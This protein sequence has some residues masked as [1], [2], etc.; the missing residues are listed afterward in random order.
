MDITPSRTAVL[1]A[2]DAVVDPKSGQGLALAG[3]V[4]G[5]SIRE[6]RIGFMLE[7]KL[8]DAELYAPVRARAEAALRALP[9]VAQAQV[10]LTTETAAPPPAPRSG[11]ATVAEDPRAALR[12]LSAARR[13]D[14]VRRVI[15]VASA[16]GGVGK[17]TV[18]ANLA[19]AFAVLGLRT[20]LA[21]TDVYGPS[22]PQMMGVSGQ[23]R[24]TAD[25]RMIPAE[26][27]GVKVTSIGLIVEESS[28]MI[29]RGPMASSAVN[30]LIHEA[31]WGSPAE[32]LDILVLDLPPGTGD[33]QLTIAQKVTL[34]GAV[35]V[36][37]PQAVAL[38][39]VRRGAAMFGKLEVPMLGVIEN[40][41]FFSDPTTGQPI[42]IFGRGGA[43]SLAET[44][45]A[46]F[47]G[48]LPIDIALRQGGDAGTPLVV[49]APESQTVAVFMNMARTLTD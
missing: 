41:A 33:I 14:H 40:M 47:L 21:D 18:A 19:C 30:Q 42:E 16:K 17:S 11:R 20:G 2:L 44:L 9:G 23:P 3:L 39:D 4:R 25:K 22:I 46:P 34:D 38:A 28:A 49:S 15:A 48:E 10:V 31:A 45:G 35:I 7:V 8:E 32:P 13:P 12:P 27:H 37:T 29:W 1:K 26:A 24:M 43:R 5:L 36:S 6:G